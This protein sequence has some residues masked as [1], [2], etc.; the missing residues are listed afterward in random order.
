MSELNK[1]EIDEIIKWINEDISYKEDYIEILKDV[2]CYNESDKKDMDSMI[3]EI[4]QQIIQ[5]NATKKMILW[6]KWSIDL[7]NILKSDEQNKM[8]WW[9]TNNLPS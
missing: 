2:L 1:K 6:S 7:L 8:S 3:N 9:K 5:L 4:K